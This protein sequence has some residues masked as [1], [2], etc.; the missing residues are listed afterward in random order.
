[1]TVCELPPRGDSFK[2]G[3]FCLKS[4]TKQALLTV[5]GRVGNSTHGCNLLKVH[6]LRVRAHLFLGGAAQRILVPRPGMELVRP[7]V[8]AESLNHWT[9]REIT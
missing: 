3:A 8:E 5:R 9:T 2:V 7:V 1:M 6:V 4:E